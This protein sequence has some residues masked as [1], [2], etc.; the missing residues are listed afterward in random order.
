VIG[1]PNL[2]AFTAG[3][4]TVGYLI[5]ALFFLRFWATSRRFLFAVFATAFVLMAGTQAIPILLGVPREYQSY[6]YLMR[7]VAFVLIIYGVLRHSF[8]PADRDDLGQ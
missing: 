6:V 3:G 2:Q 5:A 8:E 1:S 4:L 7:L